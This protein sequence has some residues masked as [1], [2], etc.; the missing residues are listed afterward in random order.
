MITDK[1]LEAFLN[2]AK[3]NELDP[4]KRT[5][6]STVLILEKFLNKTNVIINHP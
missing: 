6:L 4:L 1:D 2:T 3:I 5:H